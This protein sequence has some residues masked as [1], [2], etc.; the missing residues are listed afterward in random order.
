MSLIILLLQ[1]V[2]VQL[3]YV[4]FWNSRAWIPYKKNHENTLRFLHISASCL[5]TESIQDISLRQ[6]SLW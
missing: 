5:E 3:V 2:Y 1:L 4:E 6:G